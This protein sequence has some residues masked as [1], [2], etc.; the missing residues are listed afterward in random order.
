MRN[1][2]KIFLIGSYAYNTASKR[3][4]YFA[5][6]Y[7]NALTIL[8]R[9]SPWNFRNFYDILE[10]FFVLYNWIYVHAKPEF[11]MWSLHVIL[12]YKHQKISSSLMLS[13]GIKKYWPEIA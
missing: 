9:F 13:I 2:Q 10:L 5:F 6:F 11:S 3:S 12:T 4:T 8:L 7:D 1:F